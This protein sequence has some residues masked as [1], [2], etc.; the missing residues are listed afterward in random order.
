MWFPGEKPVQSFRKGAAKQAPERGLVLGG[1]YLKSK[2][3]L[4]KESPAD[5]NDEDLF[6][7]AESQ[8]KHCRHLLK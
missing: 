3:Q 8:P 1:L 6:L 7:L 4:A 2:G 5:G